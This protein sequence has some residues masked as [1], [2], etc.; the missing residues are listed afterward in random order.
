MLCVEFLGGSNATTVYGHRN[1]SISMIDHR[2]GSVSFISRESNGG[3][4]TSVLTFCDHNAHITVSPH[5]IIAKGSFGSNFVFDIRK[6]GNG[7]NKSNKLD[8]TS[9]LLHTLSV[10]ENCDHQ[11]KSSACSGL[12]LDPTGTVVVSP[13]I[14]NQEALRFGIWTL[15]TGKFVK[16]VL[17]KTHSSLQAPCYCELSQTA[18]LACDFKPCR[19]GFHD[20]SLTVSNDAWGLWFKCGRLNCAP[21]EFSGIHHLA[22]EGRD[23]II[24]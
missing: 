17:V 16:S 24:F 4:I 20:G 6:L 10:P 11:I 1:G 12:A 5:H 19:S 8:E 23:R 9:S 14:D 3:S 2:S 15:E 22:F 7:S 21:K 18:T 13:F